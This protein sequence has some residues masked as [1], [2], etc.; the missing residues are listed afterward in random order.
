MYN[1]P[2]FNLQA[3]IWQVTDDQSQPPPVIS[4]CQMRPHQAI[5]AQEAEFGDNS[6]TTRILFPKGTDV[7][8]QS[9]L[10]GV[11]FVEVPM[12]SGTRYQIQ[13]VVDVAK[14][15]ANEYRLAT[16]FRLTAQAPLP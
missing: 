1:L 12:G 15:F 5:S 10:L 13:T 4:A 7:R 14:G 6:G 3:G 9:E 8:G 2:N 16:G 11:S